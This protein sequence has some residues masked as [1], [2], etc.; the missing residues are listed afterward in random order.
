MKNRFLTSC[1]TCT[2]FVILM[3]DRGEVQ[4]T[5]KTM[6]VSRNM[7]LSWLQRWQAMDEDGSNL[8]DYQEFLQGCGLTDN[9]WGWRMFNLLD[10]NFTGGHDCAD[11]PVLWTASCVLFSCCAITKE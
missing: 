6:K 8:L 10:K 9:L 4:D 5:F 7:R 2:L 1:C 3:H 11:T